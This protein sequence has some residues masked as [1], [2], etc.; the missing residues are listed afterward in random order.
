[1]AEGESITGGALA[2]SVQVADVGAA[3]TAVREAG[4]RVVA[5]AA[6]GPHELRAVVQ[7]PAGNTI[8]VY[9]SS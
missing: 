7:D 6:Q 3:L 9:S 2:V 4:G 8:V 5:D 1:M